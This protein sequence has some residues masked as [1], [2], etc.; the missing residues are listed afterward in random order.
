[1]KYELGNVVSMQE[2]VSLDKYDI[3]LQKIKI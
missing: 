2:D 1:M 3:I